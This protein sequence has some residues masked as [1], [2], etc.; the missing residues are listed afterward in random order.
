MTSLSIKFRKV[1]QIPSAA[2]TQLVDR[3]SFFQL[4]SGEKVVIVPKSSFLDQVFDL[5]CYISKNFSQ[6]RLSDFRLKFGNEILDDETYLST[7]SLKDCICFD[8]EWLNSPVAL[9]ISWYGY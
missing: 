4:Q 8:F 9:Q 3:D 7:L 1:S 5:Q 6:I 2:Q